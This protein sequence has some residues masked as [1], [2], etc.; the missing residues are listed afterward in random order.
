[1]SDLAVLLYEAYR[2]GMRS[3]GVEVQEGWD[4]LDPSD[5]EAWQNVAAVA[6]RELGK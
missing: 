5:Q 2:A 1:M 4:D 3:A 6:E